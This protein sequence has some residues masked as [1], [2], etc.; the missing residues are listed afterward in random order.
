MLTWRTTDPSSCFQRTK[1]FWV[2]AHVF[3]GPKVL[4]P[5]SC[6]QRP[7]IF[8]S[9]LMFSED[10]GY[11]GLWLMFSEDQRFWIL[12]HVFRGLGF[13]DLGSCFQRTKGFFF[14]LRLTPMC[15]GFL[16]QYLQ[17][18][19]FQLVTE[20]FIEKNSAYLV[21]APSLRHIPCFEEC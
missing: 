21:N 1:Y 12:A 19:Y 6:F 5:G 11:F 2:L 13:L 16:P 8:G 3:R 18:K 4:D 14:W 20:L 17:N 7:R 15:V 10:Q 9:W